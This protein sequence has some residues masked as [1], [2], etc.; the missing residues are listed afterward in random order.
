[1]DNDPFY[2]EIF[3]KLNEH[4]DDQIFQSCAGDL[5]RKN[6]PGIVP[7]TGGDD[8]GMDGAI[9]DF[10]NEPYP[11]IVTTSDDAIGNLTRNLTTYIEEEGKQR[12]AVFATS[13]KLTPARIQNLFKRAEK[14]GFKLIQAYHQEWFANALYRD[15]AWCSRLLGLSGKPS[16]LSKI[17]L[18]SRP[19]SDLPA[20]G[21]EDDLEWL[22]KSNGDRLLV[23]QPGSGK[24]FL[25]NKFVQNNG[26]L[27][28]VSENQQDI[29]NDIRSMQPIN[30]IVDDAHT[31][32]GL[33]KNLIHLRQEL[34]T[35]FWIIASSWTGDEKEVAKNLQ[36]EENSI[37]NLNL[38]TREQIVEVINGAGLI[39]P[40]QLIKEIV[41]QSNGQP[42]LAVT[43]VQV[44]FASGAKEIF[45][46]DAINHSI[47]NYFSPI[48]G[49]ESLAVLA[50][51]AMGGDT[52]MEKKT[53]SELLG[54]TPIELWKICSQF[55]T[56]GVIWDVGRECLSVY[57]KALRYALVKEIFFISIGFSVEIFFKLFKNSPSKYDS[58]SVIV[59]SK[60]CGAAINNDFIQKQLI[61]L[62]DNRLWEQY[63]TLGKPETEWILENYPEKVKDLAIVGLFYIPDKTLPLLF[64]SAIKDNRPLNSTTNHPLR[65]VQDWI[66]SSEPGTDVAISNRVILLDNLLK[67]VNDGGDTGIGL[68][69]LDFVFSPR[70]ETNSSNPGN[71]MRMTF[72]SGCLSISE[73]D[74]LF[75]QWDRVFEF[76]KNKSISDWSPVINILPDWLYPSHLNFKVTDEIREKM[77]ELG[78]KMINDIIILVQNR[79]SFQR[80]IKQLA[81]DTGI[82]VDI[83][84]DQEFEVVYPIENWKD[85][86][87]DAEL[88]KK[89]SEKLAFFWSNQ[90][91]I[92][93][94]NKIN[95]FEKEALIS[96]LQYPRWTTFICQ[97][98]SRNTQIPIQWC[99]AAVEAD[100]EG[101]LI[102]PFLEKVAD[103]NGTE[104][105]DLA[106]QCL[107]KPK[108]SGSTI[109]FVLTNKNSPDELIIEA[110]TTLRK[111]PQK[112]NIIQHGLNRGEVPLKV[113][114]LL[115]ND[116]DTE[117]SCSAAYHE[118]YCEP[119]HNIRPE[120]Y[121]V[122]C[123]T[124]INHTVP[125]YWLC[126][127]FSE[128][129]DTAYKWLL[130]HIDN[131]DFS[132]YSNDIQTI[133]TALKTTNFDQKK[134][135]L[136]KI[137][138]EDRY[139]NFLRALIGDNLELYRILLN[140]NAL[141]VFHLE[142]LLGN[143]DNEIWI[144]K[145]KEA[146]N[147]G[148][149]PTQLALASIYGGSR[150][151]IGW[152]GHESDMWQKWIEHF[153]SL[154]NNND[155]RIKKIGDEG[156]IFAENQKIQALKK[157]HDEE[158]FGFE[159]QRR[160]RRVI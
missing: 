89:K 103:Q 33:I 86:K 53:V 77:R 114:H 101:D 25:L 133:S 31:K 68:K 6:H 50:S 38:L 137:K 148:F 22:L 147:H 71:G 84:L 122:W 75:L 26:G 105:I 107:H 34:N 98:I 57:P 108:C 82:K 94:I 91:P 8:A 157:E 118:W 15:P 117:L 135:L 124:V 7:Y 30:L 153:T 52:G 70:Y 46:G 96:N 66:E 130:A 47:S 1:M 21:R 136:Q 62:D 128:I 64:N 28:V 155:M 143:P 44:C 42:G 41:D 127:V 152:S 59:G 131:L 10:E 3:N 138:P 142:L 60:R 92:S 125:D 72:R 27:F 115:L 146:L 140:I 58:V 129:P 106:Y 79:P 4:L 56:G 37:H 55:A 149:L 119:E 97:V 93:I 158:I 63:A 12:K 61:E 113:M 80:N 159:D 100:L 104:W 141:I 69:A 32:I 123:S 156:L 144:N 5:L 132:D 88:Q 120:L 134:I 85:Y 48:L 17:P 126:E 19:F 40:D 51:F 73:I 81:I 67:W 99:K 16:A 110:I 112:N 65:V 24:T 78:Y 13:R 54:I 139:K 49:K 150:Y 111:L 35:N 76:L 102:I 116:T 83:N 14:L 18:S 39:G 160:W 45:L 11:L 9:P 36:V 23:G 43:L 121:E 154:Q 87:K 29:A 2:G 95:I 109:S 90:D 145:A 20:V 74:K 151:G